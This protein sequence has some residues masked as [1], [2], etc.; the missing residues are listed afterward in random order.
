VGLQK[1]FYNATVIQAVSEGK[2]NAYVTAVGALYKFAPKKSIR[3]KAEHLQT[4]NDKGSWASA[5]TEFSFSSP[6]AFFIS[7]LFNYGSTKN[8]YYNFG[9][10]VTRKST[11]FSLSF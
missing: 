11:R 1:I 4:E 10:S 2:V 3:F 8:H 5:L 9:A 7:D 6:Y